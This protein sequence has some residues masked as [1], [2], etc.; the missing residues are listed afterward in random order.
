MRLFALDF[1]YKSNFTITFSCLF[2]QLFIGFSF[3]HVS[4]A[5]TLAESIIHS[6]E[7]IDT[8]SVLSVAQENA[9]DLTEWVQPL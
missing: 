7:C 3:R 1:K 9:V 8:G 6:L 4:R 5:F 2:S